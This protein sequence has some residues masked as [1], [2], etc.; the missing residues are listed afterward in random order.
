MR[1]TRQ[2]PIIE[3]VEPVAP[4]A[5]VDRSA[6]ALLVTRATTSG[7]DRLTAQL[8][9]DELDGM[10][11]RFGVG[12]LRAYHA[13]FRRSPYAVSFVV[14]GQE[15]IVGFLVGTTD[16]EA[17]YQWLARHALP[18][19]GLRAILALARRPRVA[20]DALRTRRKRYLRALTRR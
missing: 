14:V 13:S 19:L 17:H 7:D 10:F 8:H 20:I 11:V 15:G 16:N 5:T 4:G 3:A 1:P 9:R 6:S 12:F 2:G 18:S